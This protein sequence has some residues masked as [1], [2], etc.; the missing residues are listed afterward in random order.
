MAGRIRL[1]LKALSLILL[2]ALLCGLAGVSAWAQS[3]Q[4]AGTVSDTSKAVI[5]NASIEI[6]NTETQVKWDATSNAE[7]R[8]VVPSLLPGRYQVIVQAPNFE[9]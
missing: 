2:F 6:V 1:R 4:I 7:G 5:P 9:S 8:Y 3:A